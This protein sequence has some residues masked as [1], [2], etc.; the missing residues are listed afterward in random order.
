MK[1]ADVPPDSRPV[2]TRDAAP[3]RIA[4]F[5]TGLSAESRCAAWLI[6]KGYRIIA[7]RFRSRAGEIDIIA[8]RRGV[9]AF[10]EVKARATLDEAAYAVTPYQQQRIVAAASAWLAAHPEYGNDELRF[11][12]MLI[13]PGH[14]P[15]HLVAAF[16]ATQS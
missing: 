8:R 14:L 10:I 1:K 5:R 7:R 6:A 11:D 2:A 13:A 15:R 16:D 4:A 12:A 9:T 3:E